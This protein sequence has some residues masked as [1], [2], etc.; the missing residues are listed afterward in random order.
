VVAG[1]GWTHSESAAACPLLR[2]QT[3][4][5]DWVTAPHAAGELHAPST[6]DVAHPE[7]CTVVCVSSGRGPVQLSDEAVSP[8]VRRQATVR[9][10]VAVPQVVDG[11][12][13]ADGLQA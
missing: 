1:F 7:V 13:H 3:T 6:Q 9:V 10:W 4:V 2:R 8:S 11:A 5:R 12:L